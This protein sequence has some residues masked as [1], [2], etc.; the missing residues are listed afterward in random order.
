MAGQ[1]SRGGF[2]PGSTLSSFYAPNCISTIHQ[3]HP[4]VLLFEIARLPRLR[5]IDTDLSPSARG[6][7]PFGPN[8]PGAW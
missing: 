6:V 1:I 7:R 4:R 3:Q 8:P 5:M 2:S